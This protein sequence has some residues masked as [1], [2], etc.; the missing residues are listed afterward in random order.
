MSVVVVGERAT[1]DGPWLEDHFLVL[2]RGDGS[3]TEYAFDAP[4]TATSST[5]SGR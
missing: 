3:W 1:G 5:G 2:V 4:E